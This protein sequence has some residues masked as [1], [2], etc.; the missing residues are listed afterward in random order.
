MIPCL[1]PVPA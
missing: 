1:E